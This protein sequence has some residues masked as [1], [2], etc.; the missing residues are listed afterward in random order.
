MNDKSA[1]VG[2]YETIAGVAFF[3]VGILADWLHLLPPGVAEL[4]MG[5][6][7]LAVSAARYYSGMQVSLFTLFLS[8]IA[9]V[10]GWNYLRDWFKFP[11]EIPGFLLLLIVLKIVWNE[12]SIM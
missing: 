9:L 12:K 5:L 6:S 2:S 7:W 4:V 10:V 11:F 1:V 3:I 8:L